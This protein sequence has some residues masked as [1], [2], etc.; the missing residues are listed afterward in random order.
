MLL[1]IATYSLSE[2]IALPQSVTPLFGEPD[3]YEY[4]D[5]PAN[6]G[7]IEASPLKA[8]SR[9]T[10]HVRDGKCKRCHEASA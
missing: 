2:G 7:D 5:R 9:T 6:Q 3:S 1:S 10:V 8:G 4:E